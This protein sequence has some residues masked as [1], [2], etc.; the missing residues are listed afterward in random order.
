MTGTL[1]VTGAGG[2]VGRALVRL[3]GLHGFEAVG[4][5]SR[6]LDV[7]DADAVAG[8]ADRYQPIAVANA[9]A[10]TKV[11]AAEADEER[12]R[13]V[14]ADGPAILARAFASVPLLHYSTDYVFDG[15][16]D[17]P[18]REDD[19]VS[20]LGAYGRTKLAGEA[21]VLDAGGTVV[22]TAWVYDEAGPNFLRTMLRAGR[23]RGAVSVVDDQHGTP[24]HAADI[25]E[26]SLRMLRRQVDERD[27]PRGLYHYTAGGQATWAGF[28]EA[29][30]DALA[31]QTGERVTLTRIGTKDYPTPAARPAYSVLDGTKV[32]RAFG[33]TRP[34]WRA[35]VAGTVE[36]ALS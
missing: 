16:G 31:E 12:A 19:P 23:E 7:T 14:N 24:T 1:L 29:I 26:A 27:A 6:E 9:A 10:Y 22:R 36:A 33:V 15:R 18:Y 20:P 32:E 3:A 28:A 17:R 5:T 2:Q 35:P 11:D 4:L 8:A 25:A 13:A 30:F 21:P 34:D